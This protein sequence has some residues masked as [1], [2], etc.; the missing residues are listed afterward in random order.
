VATLTKEQVRSRERV[1][2]AEERERIAMRM[3]LEGRTQAEI[4]KAIDRHQ[5]SV[6]RIIQTGMARRAAEDAPTVDAARALYLDRLHVLFGSWWPLA[7]G[8]YFVED[9]ETG[10]SRALPPD[11]RAGELLLKIMDRIAMASGKGIAPEGRN[12]NNLHLHVHTDGA[13]EQILGNLAT[14]AAKMHQVDGELADVGTS[15]DLLSGKTI[16]DSKPAPP[17]VAKKD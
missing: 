11:P 4:G 12:E 17:P 2:A 1:T 5:A 14:M 7:T 16:I 10:E 15:V 6:S 9:D 3:W 8:T 13:R